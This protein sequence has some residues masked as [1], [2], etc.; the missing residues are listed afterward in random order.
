MAFFKADQEVVLSLRAIK[1]PKAPMQSGVAE[2]DELR[3]FNILLVRRLPRSN[4]QDCVM[5]TSCTCK[6]PIPLCSYD[7]GGGATLSRK[8]RPD[9]DCPDMQ[10]IQ[11]QFPFASREFPSQYDVPAGQ[12]SFLPAL[13]RPQSIRKLH[14]PCREAFSG[15]LSKENVRR[16]KVSLYQDAERKRS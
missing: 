6:Y 7:N 14:L 8:S 10:L 16:L 3:E 15:H 2:R 13:Q 4:F 12:W 5:D 9:V 1:A 11:A